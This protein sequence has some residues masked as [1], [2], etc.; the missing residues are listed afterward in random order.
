MDQVFIVSLYWVL[1][2]EVDL[3]MKLTMRFSNNLKATDIKGGD[4]CII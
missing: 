2:E 1:S 4:F 3:R